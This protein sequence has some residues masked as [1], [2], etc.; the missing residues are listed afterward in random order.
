MEVAEKSYYPYFDYLRIA[1]AAVVMLYHDN[2]I[3]W[4]HALP[5]YAEN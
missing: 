4:H 2:I 1:L 3:G 5:M